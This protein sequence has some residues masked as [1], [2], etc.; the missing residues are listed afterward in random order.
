MSFEW[1]CCGLFLIAALFYVFYLPDRIY[2]GPEKTRAMYLRERKDVVYENLRDLNFEYRAGK[3]PDADYQSLK[4]MMITGAVRGR[5]TRQ[6]TFQEEAPSTRAASRKLV[7]MALMED[8]TSRATNG[9]NCQLS[10]RTMVYSA[11]FGS[12]IHGMGGTWRNE[13]R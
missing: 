1:A 7:G 5:M 4:A 8:R 3:V 6:N 11:S 13:S 9:M 10:T 2:L 12:P